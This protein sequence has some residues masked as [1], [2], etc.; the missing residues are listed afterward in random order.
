MREAVMDYSPV[1]IRGMIDWP[2]L[3][4][5]SVDYLRQTIPKDEL[6]KVNYTTNGLADS[7]IETDEY[8]DGV[9]VYPLEHEMNMGAFLDSM[10]NIEEDDAVPYLSIQNDNFRSSSFE[11]LHADVSMSIPLAE[12]AFGLDA[13]EAVRACNHS[14]I[15]RR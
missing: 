15:Y 1:I 3:D 10:E 5:W 9:F 7:V 8:P 14:Y 2:A 12:E 11:P 6:F 13:P 4:K